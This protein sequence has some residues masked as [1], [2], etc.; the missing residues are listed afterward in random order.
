MIYKDDGNY[1]CFDTPVE[2]IR[3]GVQTTDTSLSLTEW[4]RKAGVFD[5]YIARICKYNFIKEWELVLYKEWLYNKTLDCDTSEFAPFQKRKFERLRK[6]FFKLYITDYDF[7]DSSRET[8][9]PIKL[10]EHIKKKTAT[11]TKSGLKILSNLSAT[12]RAKKYLEQR[13]LPMVDFIEGGF[14]EFDSGYQTYGLIIKYQNGFRK[15]RFINDNA[16][17]RYMANND[18]GTY[19]EFLKVQNVGSRKLI[20]CEGE[21]DALSLTFHKDA[22]DYDIYAMHNVISLPAT[23]ISGFLNRYDEVF[24]RIDRKDFDRNSQFLFGKIKDVFKGKVYCDP[25]TPTN[26]DYNDYLVRGELDNIEIA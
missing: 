1:K 5:V 18:N 22:K 23:D 10:R 20:L 7:F 14:I 17:L 13:G 25:K 26:D 19:D 6:E 24:I 16:S 2:V 11:K 8:S 15:I 3:G 4:I 12:I 9:K 21:L